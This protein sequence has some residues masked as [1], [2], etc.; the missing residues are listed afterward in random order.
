MGATK[1]QTTPKQQKIEGFK[2][3]EIAE[4]EQAAERYREIRDERMRL[5]KEESEENRKLVEIMQKHGIDKY[6]LEDGSVAELVEETTL[7]AKVRKPAKAEE[8]E[9]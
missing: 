3:P 6:R 8:P 1:K 4:V 5:A 9:E 7:K 2:P